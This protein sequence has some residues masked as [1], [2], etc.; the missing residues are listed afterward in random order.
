MKN[1]M[2]VGTTVYW[3]SIDYENM[4]NFVPMVIHPTINIHQGTIVKENK[5]GVVIVKTRI[6]DEYLKNFNGHIN[7]GLK[8]YPKKKGE[9]GCMAD[10]GLSKYSLCV[11]MD[12]IKLKYLKFIMNDF[13][14]N[15]INQ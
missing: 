1:N 8:L 6:N 5:N 10:V 12:E 7:C 14:T 9:I 2:K 3:M 4:R 11:S 15:E 13:D